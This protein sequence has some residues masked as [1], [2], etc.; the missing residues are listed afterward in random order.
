[1][2]PGVFHSAVSKVLKG[3]K[4]LWATLSSPDLCFMCAWLPFPGVDSS[5]QTGSWSVFARKLT[6]STLRDTESAR[7]SSLNDVNSCQNSDRVRGGGL[8][9]IWV[10][11]FV[12]FINS[13]GQL[14][15]TSNCCFKRENISSSMGKISVLTER[16]CGRE[17][18]TLPLFESG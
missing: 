9:S 16:G 12:N 15:P 3:R 1:M 17:K 11:P 10:K 8:C 6:L 2:W 14:N 13:K 18:N 7:S 4:A 5:F